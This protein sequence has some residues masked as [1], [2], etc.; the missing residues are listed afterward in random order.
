MADSETRDTAGPPEK[1]QT[2]SEA[3]QGHEVALLLT[4]AAV[5]AALMGGRASALSASA[6]TSWQEAT[7]LQV[8]EAAAYVEQIRYIYGVEVPR[9]VALME[10]RFRAEELAKIVEDQDVGRETLAFLEYEQVVQEEA[11]EASLP[12]ST[13]AADPKYR[14]DVGFDPLIMLE[15]ERASDPDL[16][17]VDPGAAHEEGD[18]FSVDAIRMIASTAPVAIA[19]LCGSMARVFS[20]GRRMWIT[21]G[22][23]MLV[24]GAASA[25]VVEVA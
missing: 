10:T 20:R 24:V 17:E 13:L 5:L 9:A 25:V 21:L 7:R 19:F 23:V 16:L 3:R 8:K 15:E 6:S 14:T 2:K 18:E 4:A 1:R 11:L 12:A 22:L